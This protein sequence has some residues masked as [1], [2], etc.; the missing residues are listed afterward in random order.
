VKTAERIYVASTC[1]EGSEARLA[2]DL[3]RRIEDDIATLALPAGASLGSLRELSERYRAGRS[4]VREA[5]ALLERRGLGRLRP[6]PCGGFILAKPSPEA[7]GAALAE[8]FGA[9]GVTALQVDDAREAA[10]RIHVEDARPD[11]VS[12]LLL[13]CLAGLDD[14]PVAAPASLPS[15]TR[16]T[17]IARRLALEIQKARGSGVRLGSEWDLCERYGVSRLT[18]RQAIRVLQDSGLVAC[19]RG[20]GNG[21]IVRDRRLAGS[22]RLMLAY[23]ISEQLDP[24][25][26]GTILIQLN[27]HVPALAVARATPEQRAHLAEAVARLSEGDSLDRCELLALVQ[28]VARLADSPIIDLFSRGLA[29][30]EARFH[31]SLAE[32]LP[33][34]AQASYFRMMRALLDRYA[35]GRADPDWARRTSADCMMEMSRARPI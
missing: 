21:L 2:E 6:G 31:P 10:G 24:R 20:R 19:R 32:R 16:A 3:A 18:L 23:F 15:G 14:R 1:D 27:S 33:V 17:D 5:M 30:Y 13:A 11:P 34:A 25:V 29:A 8:H 35:S 22:I 28:T 26:A 7:I 9:V 12:R 4:V